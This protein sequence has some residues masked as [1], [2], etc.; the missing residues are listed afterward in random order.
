MI[1][2]EKGIA[3]VSNF[4]GREFLIKRDDLLSPTINGNKAYKFFFLLQKNFN[5]IVSYGGN[6][7][8]A[9]LCLSYIAKEK[10]AKFTYFTPPLSN[11][12]KNNIHGNF[13]LAKQNG[14]II[15]ESKE[16]LETK[17][18]TF[19]KENN[20]IFINQGGNVEQDEGIE[21]LA[22]QILNLDKNNLCVFC[23][24]GSGIS[25]F[26]LQNKLDSIDV[27]TTPCVG[28][29]EFLIKEFEKFKLQFES[30]PPFESK[31]RPIFESK[32][33][34]KTPRII[35]PKKKYHFAKPNIDLLNIYKEWLNK[36]IEFDLIYDCVMWKAIEDNLQNLEYENY[37]FL[38]S[39]GL[40]ANESILERYKFLNIL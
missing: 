8:N 17:A 25:A 29:S 15:K 21:K 23:S 18:K 3:E 28:G 39:G 1:D 13:K 35:L 2:W 26:L 36:G 24:S 38:H 34:F 4:K 33:T 9:M 31:F 5:H 32:S 27:I 22:R 30:K 19:A 16:S 7:S 11:Y 12:L 6:Q 14:A 10:N 40:S 37:L 20:A